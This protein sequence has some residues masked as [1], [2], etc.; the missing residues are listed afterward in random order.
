MTKKEITKLDK[1]VRE[2]VIERDG[3]RCQYCGQDGNNV[4]HL[5]GRRNRSTRWFIDNLLLLCPGC[6]TFKTESFHQNPLTTMKWFEENY[7]E[8]YQAINERK[9]KILKQTFDE[10]WE[11]LNA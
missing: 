3:G 11:E 1:K 4:H 5:I 2:Y 9:N 8:R 10:V 6:H 7:P